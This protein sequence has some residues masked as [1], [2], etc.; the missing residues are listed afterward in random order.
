MIAGVV[1][2]GAVF[3]SGFASMMSSACARRCCPWARLRSPARDRGATASDCSIQFAARA[4]D[5]LR[6]SR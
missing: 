3:E 6:D 5:A 1:A 2:G 4:R